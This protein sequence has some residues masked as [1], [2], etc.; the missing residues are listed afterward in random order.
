MYVHTGIRHEFFPW[1]E[2]PFKELTGTQVTKHPQIL[3]MDVL[4]N[5]F[6]GINGPDK[7]YKKL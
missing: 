4:E 5:E 6:T 7:F 2:N 1:H 3:T